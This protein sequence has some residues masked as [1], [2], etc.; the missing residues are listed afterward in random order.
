MWKITIYSRIIAGSRIGYSFEY[1]MKL[2]SCP[3]IIIINDD[4]TFL[5]TISVHYIVGGKVYEKFAKIRKRRIRN[6]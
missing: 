3:E 6:S 4:G 5:S 1:N 2:L